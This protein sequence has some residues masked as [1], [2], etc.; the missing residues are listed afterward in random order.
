VLEPSGEVVSFS[1]VDVVGIGPRAMFGSV[2]GWRRG[3]LYEFS[4]GEHGLTFRLGDRGAI[5]VKE[6][7]LTWTPAG[8]GSPQTAKL[9]PLSDQ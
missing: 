2:S 5:T 8:G 4:A 1:T 3:G 7:T 9:F 6:T